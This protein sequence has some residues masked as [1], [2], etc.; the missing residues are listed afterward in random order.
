MA[1]RGADISVTKNFIGE[2]EKWINKANV[3]HEGAD[4]LTQY[5][6]YSM[7]VQNFKIL[8]R[9]V[10]EKSLTKNFIGEKKDGQIK[11]MISMMILILFYTIQ[12]VIP[13]ISKLYLI[14]KSQVQ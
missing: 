8:G 4:S 7:F 14:L 1:L 10:P 5:M 2:K 12:L 11:E 6:S 3:K 13:D 9:V